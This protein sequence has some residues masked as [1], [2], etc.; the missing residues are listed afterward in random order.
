MKTTKCTFYDLIYQDRVVQFRTF[1]TNN[2]GDNRQYT[3]VTDPESTAWDNSR[4][5][6]HDETLTV[7]PRT[8]KM[9]ENAFT[10][11]NIAV[12]EMIKPIRYHHWT[13]KHNIDVSNITDPYV[14]IST[15]S[16][17][18]SI[19]GFEHLVADICT[20]MIRQPDEPV[21]IQEQ[22]IDYT[23]VDDGRWL[24]ASRD[25]YI[26]K[27]MLRTTKTDNVLDYDGVKYYTYQSITLPIEGNAE[28]TFRNFYGIHRVY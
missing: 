10:V 6:Y 24:I 16:G 17:R 1:W 7:A 3:L 19:I 20:Y 28:S 2:L 23:P 15:H 11:A 25:G 14:G 5:V 13:G 27:V 8:V 12:P 4:R 21:Y 9:L 18:V 26:F 22:F